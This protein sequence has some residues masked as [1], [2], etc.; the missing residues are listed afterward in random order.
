MI[1]G[2]GYQSIATVRDPDRVHFL[3]LGAAGGDREGNEDCEGGA[4][5]S[6]VISGD[7]NRMGRSL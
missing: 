2:L 7:V 1:G 6:Q 4:E 3:R 5:S